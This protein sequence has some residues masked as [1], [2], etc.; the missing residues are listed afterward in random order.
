MTLAGHRG[1][2]KKTE[3]NNSTMTN[4]TTLILT[5][6]LATIAFPAPGWSAV[7]I[8]QRGYFYAMDVT[9]GVAANTFVIGDFGSAP[10]LAPPAKSAVLAGLATE[11]AQ[12]S[13]SPVVAPSAGLVPPILF[14]FASA[15][16]PVEAEASVI[17]SLE[18]KVSPATPLKVTGYTCDLGSQKTN[19]ALALRRARAVA[20]MLAPY[21]YK[22]PEVTG[23]GKRD[24]VSTDP[25]TRYLNRRVE[26]N[27]AT[28]ANQE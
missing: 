20:D 9:Q 15:V 3:A 10:Q 16:V 6:I 28:T 5:A 23:K 7:A 14:P 12:P 22:V 26:I 24:Y 27:I 8:E 4:R 13:S 2:K 1:E 11:T 21:G 17:P 18:K 25:A 19:D